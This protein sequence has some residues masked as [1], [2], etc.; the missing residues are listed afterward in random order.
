MIETNDLQM[1]AFFFRAH[2]A[3]FALQNFFKGLNTPLC[4]IE[5]GLGIML[6]ENSRRYLRIPL[7]LLAIATAI[8][9]KVSG[10]SLDG[11]NADR[12]LRRSSFAFPEISPAGRFFWEAVPQRNG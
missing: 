6:L 5:R 11:A 1:I 10:L 4:Q 2:L 8:A 7:F 3:F 9:F 12:T